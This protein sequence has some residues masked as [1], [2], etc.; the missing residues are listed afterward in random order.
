[1]T[2]TFNA[3]A[4]LNLLLDVTAKR[5]D[6]YHDI[7]SVMQTVDLHDEIA[8]SVTPSSCQKSG[9]VV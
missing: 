8:I 2:K 9:S 7:A 5:P 4:K 6:G 3:Y 1:M